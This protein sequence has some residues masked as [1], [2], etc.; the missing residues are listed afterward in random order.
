MLSG[1]SLALLATTSIAAAQHDAPDDHDSSSSPP[2]R[3]YILMGQ[4]NMV[5]FG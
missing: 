3:V 1:L 5:G 4:S 2:I